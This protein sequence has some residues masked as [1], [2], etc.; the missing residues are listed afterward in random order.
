MKIE[1]FRWK[2]K[3][4]L[5]NDNISDNSDIV[6]STREMV[7]FSCRENEVTKLNNIKIFRKKLNLT[8]KQLSKKSSVAVGYISTL[9]NDSD[10]ITNPTKETMMKI[11]NALGKSVPDVFFPNKIK[12]RKES[13]LDGREQ[14]TN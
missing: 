2:R 7:L 13:K 1:E 14:A 12:V 5:K 8:V 4:F 3:L 9:E 11:A 6:F 10:D